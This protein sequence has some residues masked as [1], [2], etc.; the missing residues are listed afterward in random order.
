MSCKCFIQ[1]PHFRSSA[2]F[3][4]R[5]ESSKCTCNARFVVSEKKSRFE[6]SNCT[7]KEVDKYKVDNYLIQDR[8]QKKCD[9]YFHYHSD[10]TTNVCIFVEL[11]GI[12]IETA[13]KQLDETITYFESNH[14]FL[15][16]TNPKII[17][18]IV[19]TG[20]PSNDA[21]YRR[22]VKNLISHHKSLQPTIQRS[23]Y[24]M[25]YNPA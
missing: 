1:V 24:N 8:T 3:E 18:A 23:T 20:Y 19:S 13:V 4:E 21:T 15:S 5:L 7:L 11:K 22:A 6:L 25:R 10:S 9:Y 14:Y 2:T 16:L 17:C 12:D